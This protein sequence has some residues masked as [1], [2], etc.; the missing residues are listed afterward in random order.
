M[1]IVFIHPSQAFLP[2]L[3]AYTRYFRDRNVQTTISTNTNHGIIAAVEWYFMGIYTKRK[4]TITIHEYA[5]ASVPP[6]ASMKDFVKRKFNAVPDFR[7]YNNEYVR[8]QMNFRDQIPHGIR[9]FGIDMPSIKVSPVKKE[10]DFI[11]TGSVAPH[12]KLGPL[13]ECF[14]T[15]SMRDHSLLIL[16]NHYEHLSATMSNYTNIHFAGPVPLHEVRGYLEKASFGINYMVD[17]LPFNK[18]TSAK[19]IEYAAAG[20]P[21]ITTAYEWVNEFE[22]R[23]GG[24]FFKLDELLSN[25]TWELLNNFDYK[26]PDLTGWTWEEQIEKC[27]VVQFLMKQKL[28]KGRRMTDDGRQ[29][30]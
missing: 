10:Y 13:L 11:Y 3:D 27:G 5:S 2:E 29:T 4:A 14:T 25:F 22:K 12:R 17:E 28:R 9:N 18:Q 7:I 23:S 21:V 15:G 24:S 6:L 1:H 30:T 8:Q 20:L 16:S 26:T 19:L